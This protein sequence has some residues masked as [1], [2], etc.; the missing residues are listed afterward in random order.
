[1]PHKHIYFLT[2]IFLNYVVAIFRK[3]PYENYSSKVAGCRRTVGGWSLFFKDSGC[4][5]AALFLKYLFFMSAYL[6]GG[7]FFL[8]FSDKS[9]FY[10]IMFI[11]EKKSYFP[12]IW[13]KVFD[14]KFLFEWKNF[15]LKI[16]TI[17]GNVSWQV[18]SIFFK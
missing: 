2:N 14:F 6:K 12:K 13:K 7:W 11:H 1:M 3:Y 18:K 15:L 4:T 5:L 8:Y 10:E 17:T 16:A 9:I